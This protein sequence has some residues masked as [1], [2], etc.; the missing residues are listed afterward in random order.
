MSTEGV[1]RRNLLRGA[2]GVTLA[3]SAGPALA[4]SEPGYDGWFE[5][6]GNFDETVDKRGQDEVT[7]TV[8]AQGN[9]GAFA[10]DPPAV[11]ISRGTTIVWEWTGNG[12]SHNVVAEN[13]A[14]ESELVGDSGHTFEYTFE[15]SG[16]VKYAC[17]PHKTAG[18]KGAVVV[19]ESSGGDGAGGDESG[20]SGVPDVS[21]AAGAVGVSLLL[22]FLSPLGLA[23]YLRKKDANGA[24][25][26]PQQPRSGD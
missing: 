12:G 7:I 23:A 8:G 17:T 20:S 19:S 16:I 25:A 24:P 11:R 18:M 1:T 14:F 9:G 15:E 21:P 22:A 6:V 5:D 26:P 13:G 2:A 4:Q 3:A 10:F